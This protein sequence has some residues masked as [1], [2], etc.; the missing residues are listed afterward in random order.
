MNPLDYSIVIPVYGGVA[1]IED[2]Y[3]RLRAVFDERGASVE[4]IFVDDASRDGS[5]HVIERL[6][7]A[8][9]NVRGIRLG[10]N[11]GQHN[12]TT[13]GFRFARGRFVVTLDEDLQH[14]P[15]EI[16]KL[17]QCQQRGD[18]DVVYGIPARRRSPFWRRLGS[19]LAMAIPR[20]VM[21][22]HF[23]ISSFRLVR[24]ALAR[25]VACSTRH[26]IIVDAYLGWLT[27]RIAAT[28]V[29]HN[30][31]SRCS[32]YTLLRLIGLFAN[33]LCNYTTFPLRVATA[34]GGLLSMGSILVGILFILLHLSGYTGVPGYSSLI[35]SLFFST[36][37][38]LMGIG[39]MSEYLGRI[40][41][42]INGRPQAYIRHTTEASD[43]VDLRRAA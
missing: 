14:P 9:A 34:C 25:E 29:R 32:N 4:V 12:A 10:R 22:I 24:A 31:A 27:D 33:L 40:L 13:C 39:V 41:M 3:R 30:A 16:A 6:A 8:N 15:E 11:F 28:E 21:K 2:L 37:V 17:I 7:R 43:E 1:T 5:W 26:D 18:A 42:Q 19:R 23:D 36:G 38:I 35:V 20:H